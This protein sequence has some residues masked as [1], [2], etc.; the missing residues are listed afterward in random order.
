MKFKTMRGVEFQMDLE[1]ALKF[2]GVTLAV[3]IDGYMKAGP[4]YVHRLILE[5]KE[6]EVVDH[7]NGDP[8]DN[9]RSNLRICTVQENSC[10]QKTRL[11]N[12]TGARGVHWE[13]GRGKWYAKVTVKGRT[14]FVGRYD[15]L[16]EAK[17]ARLSAE[18]ILHG[19][20]A[21]AFGV[22]RERK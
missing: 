4:D 18:A 16:D 21:G 2:V 15:T 22:N 5:P 13:A 14:V 20:F 6:G 9:R 17:A 12:K 7:I 19:Q 8:L 11:G 10:N 1:D 3:R